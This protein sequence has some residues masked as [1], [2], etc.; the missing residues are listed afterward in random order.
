GSP[1]PPSGPVLGLTKPI[2]IVFAASACSVTF[3]PASALP[4]KPPEKTTP[5]APTPARLTSSRRE[6]GVS[7]SPRPGSLLIDRPP[8]R[9]NQ[10]PRW[11]AGESRSAPSHPSIRGSNY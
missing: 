8:R 3:T 10:R 11:L 5:A 4:A 7:S 1:K 6:I 2:L 9:G